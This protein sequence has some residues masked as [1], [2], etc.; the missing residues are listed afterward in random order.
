LYAGSSQNTELRQI[1]SYSFIHLA[2]TKIARPLFTKSKRYSYY[3]PACDVSKCRPIFILFLQSETH[4]THRTLIV[5]LHYLLEYYTPFP[6]ALE[7]CPFL[8]HP[9]HDNTRKWHCMVM[10][11]AYYPTS[12]DT[13]C[14]SLVM[15]KHLQ[16]TSMTVRFIICYCRCVCDFNHN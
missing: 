2:Q 11:I 9:A 8:H 6:L 14:R 12:N 4:D 13:L 5:S 7:N 1:Y 10:Y 15:S 16:H 3:T